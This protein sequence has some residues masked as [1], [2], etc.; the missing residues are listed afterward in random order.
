VIEDL[1]A[2]C[3]VAGEIMKADPVEILNAHAGVKRIDVFTKV[4]DNPDRWTKA[5]QV[6]FSAVEKIQTSILDKFQAIMEA[7][8][9]KPAATATEQPTNEEAGK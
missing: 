6:A 5:R 3:T 7:E 9:V 4:Q 8:E 2:L 1:W